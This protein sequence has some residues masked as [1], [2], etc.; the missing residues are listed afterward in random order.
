M[1]TQ[2]HPQQQNSNGR[3]LAASALIAIAASALVA[4]PASAATFVGLGSAGDFAVLAGS[5]ITNTGATTINGDVGLTPGT[6]I[7]GF[8]TVTLLGTTH[9]SDGPATDA[10][11]DFLIA[12]AAAAS[13]DADFT[14][15][16]AHDLGGDIL[17]PGVHRSDSSFLLNGILTLDGAGDSAAV[18]IFQMGSTLTTGSA[19]SI[20]LINGAQAGNVF[21]QVGSSA[22][23]GSSS[24][25]AGTILAQ[26]AISLNAGATVEG[27]VLA[28][29]DAVTMIG[30][31]INIP[32]PSTFLLL[33][34]A[35]TAAMFTRRRAR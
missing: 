26:T 29:D 28:R 34:G 23:L 31:T 22:T 32:E 3:S 24:Q 6:S 15:A 30:N 2:I 4:S 21:W 7:T 10:K 25:M 27:R 9:I 5:T 19:S 11:A 12:Y 20:N 33:A 18:W 35:G 13:Q 1:N 14:Y 8:G 16:G 17:G